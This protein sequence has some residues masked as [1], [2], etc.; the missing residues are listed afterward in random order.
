LRAD[1]DRFLSTADA[2]VSPDP[3]NPLN[4]ASTMIK[5]LEYMAY[6]CPIVQ[7]DLNEGRRSSGDASLYAHC[8]DPVDFAKRI[9][10]LLNSEALRKQLSRNGRTR[11]EQD[12]N[13]ASERASLLRAYATV[14]GSIKAL[15]S[16]TPGDS[17]KEE[18]AVNVFNP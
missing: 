10:Q 16:S 3:C 9:L 7:F 14:R 13:W 8:N 1:I 15:P 5:T 2:A 17:I 6:G 12:V 11:V 4:D 18:S